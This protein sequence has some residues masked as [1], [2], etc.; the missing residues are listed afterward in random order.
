MNKDLHCNPVAATTKRTGFRHRFIPFLAGGSLLL[1]LTCAAEAGSV[2][3]E[4]KVV[5]A[6]LANRQLESLLNTKEAA[7]WELVQINAQGVAILKRRK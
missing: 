6:G 2:R 7:G 1:L 4:Y 3:W 5:N